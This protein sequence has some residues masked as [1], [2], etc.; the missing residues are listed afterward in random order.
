V[1]ARRA[2]SHFSLMEIDLP[3]GFQQ[4]EYATLPLGKQQVDFG[5][6]M[7]LCLADH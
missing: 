4:G 7:S 3:L 5:A 2:I 1:F 6:S